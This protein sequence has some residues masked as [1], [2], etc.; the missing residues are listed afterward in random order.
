MYERL[1]I[2]GDIV[3]RVVHLSDIHFAM[4]DQFEIKHFII[5]PLL[6]DLK[7]F[8]ERIKIDLII[9]S[10]DLIDKGGVGSDPL[11]AFMT[12][13]E[14]VIDSLAEGLQIRKDQIFFAPGNHDMIRD[15]DTYLEELGLQ[16]YLQSVEA[17]NG[18]MKKE[19]DSGIK[20][21]KQFKDFEASYYNSFPDKLLSKY[22]SCFKV[23]VGQQH[24]GIT[25]FNSSWRSYKSEE[26]KG[27]LILGQYQILKAAD[28]NKD[29]TTKIAVMHH[30]FD[31][32]LPLEEYNEPFIRQDFDILLTGHVHYPSAWS[33]TDLYGNLLVSVAPSNWI[34]GARKVESNY[35]NG[36]TIIDYDDFIG[37]AVV[38]HRRYSYLKREYV[39]NTD[40][41]DDRGT[42]VYN[43]TPPIEMQKQNRE[44]SI[45]RSINEIYCPI[46]N[47]RLLSYN[48]DTSAPKELE[49]IFV[50]PRIVTKI[51]FDAEKQEEVVE[52]IEDLCGNNNN[53]IIFGTKESGKTA[54]MDRLLLEFTGNFQKHHRIPVE[55]DFNEIGNRIETLISQYLSIGI[56][57]IDTF[58]DNSEIVLLID[59][60][61]FDTGNEYS[62][63]KITALLNKHPKV[64]I[65]ATCN[66]RTTGESPI[67][68]FKFPSFASM[69]LSHISDFRTKEIKELISKW[70]STNKKHTTKPQVN[71]ILNTFMSL[72]LPRTPLALSMFLWII[73]QQENYKPINN[74]AMLDNYIERLFKKSSKNQVY[75]EEFD[76]QNKQRLLADIARIML[77]SKN[78][79]YCL[80]YSELVQF[81]INYF[82]DRKFEFDAEKIINHF[83]LVGILIVEKHNSQ[84]C[85]RFRFNCFFQYYLTKKMEYDPNF[86]HDVLREENYLKFVDE[87]DYF[88]GLKRDQSE[89]LKTLVDRMNNEFQK[90]IC[91]ISK[92]P[93]GF[94]TAFIK[95]KED[96]VAHDFEITEF[97]DRGKPTQQQL[98][99]IQDEMLEEMSNT[100]GVEL[101]EEKLDLITKLDRTWQI[102]GRVLKNTEEIIEEDLKANALKS[103]ITAGM[104][105]A[106]FYKYFL[107]RQ[108]IKF[109][110]KM[111]AKVLQNINL[112]KDFMPLAYQIILFTT[113]GT[114]KLSLVLKEKLDKELTDSKIS[115]FEK[116]ITVFF[117]ADIRGENYLP[118]IRRLIGNIEQAYVYDL[119]FFKLVSYY[120]LRSKTEEDDLVLL[121]MLADI[122]IEM[123]GTTKRRDKS[124]IIQHYRRLK[125]EQTKKLRA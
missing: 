24:I 119:I 22:Q 45:V 87:I 47:E 15:Q 62:L 72:N 55:I 92:S 71:K 82:N 65:I 115:D 37:Q 40:I 69:Q 78:E 116:F 26:D 17:I 104:A 121:N 36:Y 123:T 117:L 28:F 33:K 56:L 25:C 54:L 102:A 12:F 1:I 110:D 98:E 90:Y 112:L 94:D 61:S 99:S 73:E 79:N 9:L 97:I 53:L 44:L 32:F 122:N 51:E 41:G 74:A 19:E 6:D 83:L 89:I 14:L 125:E 18:F 114:G 67:E 77:I 107:E 75:S 111:D 46:V 113:T 34:Y 5:N 88:T 124:L 50:F 91:L 4:K 64:K 42:V 118:Y 105:F 68:L 103:V 100:D 80:T 35:T 58:L 3:L 81:V 106:F 60:L 10:G 109:S 86:R 108:V 30:P 57:E 16:S 43:F 2:G 7:T 52:R 101:K 39:S 84:K 120:L 70:F 8:H 96:T 20:R 13:E 11:V 49:R 21:T 66:Q 95:A 31:W 85:I 76:Y 29:C 23:N 38:T 59:N 93:Q 48:T 63:Q 27:R